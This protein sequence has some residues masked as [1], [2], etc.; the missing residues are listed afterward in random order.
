MEYKWTER[1]MQ[2]ALVGKGNLFDFRRYAV[3]PNVS[4]AVLYNG[5]ADLLC[6]S[7]SNIF[8]EVEIKISLADMKNEAKKR[9]SRYCNVV[10][11]KWIAAP[12][13]IAAKALELECIPRT[14]GV[15]SVSARWVG[16]H[17]YGFGRVE[18]DHWTFKTKKL[19]LPKRQDTVAVSNDK[20]V[21]FYR[22]GIMRMWTKRQNED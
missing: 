10:A 5:E 2:F 15:I 12:E 11:Y 13:E 14:W 18:P 19:R 20:I 4:Y 8:H 6:L 16:E 7:K 17:K 3:V 21:A 1:R 9:R 22:T